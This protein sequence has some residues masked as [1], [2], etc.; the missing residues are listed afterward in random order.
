MSRRRFSAA[1]DELCDKVPSKAPNSLFPR[2]RS[3][4]ASL[5][6]LS[7]R[8]LLL[9]PRADKTLVSRFA[10]SRRTRFLVSLTKGRPARFALERELSWGVI[11][12][13]TITAEATVLR[14][15][16]RPIDRKI[17]YADLQ[18]MFCHVSYASRDR[19]GLSSSKLF[20]LPLICLLRA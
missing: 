7:V 3:S 13:G 19:G 18:M 5:N 9:S 20:S 16:V 17:I 12:S 8:L 11:C 1:D 4:T 2:L 6:L 15:V 10:L 14:Y